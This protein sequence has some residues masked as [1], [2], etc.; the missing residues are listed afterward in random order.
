MTRSGS[1]SGWAHRLL[2]S[3]GVTEL[4]LSTSVARSCA[5]AAWAKGRAQGDLLYPGVMGRVACGDAP[6]LVG[7]G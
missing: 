7:G 3:T 4:S 5:S 2:S 1:D 6:S